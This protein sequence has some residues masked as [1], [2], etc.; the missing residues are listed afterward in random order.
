MIVIW[1]PV[2]DEALHIEDMLRSVLAQTWRDW[3]LV[4]SDNYS[5]DGTADIVRRYA[6]LDGRITLVNPP[7]PMTGM[8]HANWLWAKLVQ[9]NN[10][11]AAMFIGGHDTVSQ[12]YV[13]D[14][15]AAMASM[16]GVSCTYAKT[17]YMVDDENRIVHRWGSCPQTQCVAQP[18]AFLSLLTQMAH[19]IPLFGLMRWHAFCSATPFRACTGHDNFICA[20]LS[21]HGDLYQVAGPTLCL[22]RSPGFGDYEVYRAK[23]LTG[24]SLLDDLR[25]Q[26]GWL[27]SLAIRACDNRD[28]NTRAAVLAMCR[29][30]YALA[31]LNLDDAGTM[32]AIRE[33]LPDVWQ[34]IERA[35]TP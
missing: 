3:R 11:T 29:L 31:R 10:A 23:H 5:T 1:S 18:Y 14:L 22:R 25:A 28:G 32:E 17:A 6:G 9:E 33:H 24:T 2:R 12:T 15:L 27:D 34:T 21:L 30:S 7:E 13:E 16:P 4:V 26:F 8:G 35:V 19:N 20:E